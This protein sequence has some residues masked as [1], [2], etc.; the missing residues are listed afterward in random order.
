MV[1]LIIQ[2]FAIYSNEHFLNPIKLAKV[3]SN[4]AKN[5]RNIQEKIAK[6]LKCSKKVAK[7][8]QIWSYWTIPTIGIRV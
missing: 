8:R 7:L 5:E 2:Y 1:I 4:F 3:G 6:I